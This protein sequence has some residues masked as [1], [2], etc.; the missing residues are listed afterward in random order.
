MRKTLIAALVIAGAASQVEAQHVKVATMTFSLTHQYQSSVV[1]KSG[2]AYE[3]A[4][5]RD[6][7]VPPNWMSWWVLDNGLNSVKYTSK[8]KKIT[9]ANVISAISYTLSQKS[10]FSS[11]ARLVVVDYENVMTFPPYPNLPWM[12][13]AAGA[14][15]T[16]NWPAGGAN[17]P[18]EAVIRWNYHYTTAGGELSDLGLGA[19]GHNTQVW[20]LDAPNANPLW[21]AVNVSPFFEIEENSCMFCWDTVNRVTDGNLTPAPNVACIG[22]GGG[23]SGC[24]TTKWYSIVKFNN[25]LGNA[26]IDPALSADAQAYYAETAAN[27]GKGFTTMAPAPVGTGVAGV[28]RALW[29]TVGGV[30]T[31][32]WC[33]KALGTD[34]PVVPIGTMNMSS[35]QGYGASPFCG[36]VTGSVTITEKVEQQ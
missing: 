13:D 22:G 15:P 24:G 29:F 4:R 11:Q 34:E 36:V 23:V 18:D 7:S 6:N 19:E 14:L 8:T 31:Y 9:T 17:W 35:A 20:I 32:K 27:G 3:P 25:T 28:D 10:V 12:I 2:Y 16:Y 1:D 21:R 30:V 26:H 5:P 33:Y